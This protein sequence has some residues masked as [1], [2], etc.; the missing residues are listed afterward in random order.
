MLYPAELRG[1]R[2]E[3]R[4]Y[5]IEQVDSLR[6]FKFADR[7]TYSSLEVPTNFSL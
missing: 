2:L 5:Q 7:G 3:F 6:S 4:S 1:L